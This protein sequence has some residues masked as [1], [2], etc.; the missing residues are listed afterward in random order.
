MTDQLS[1]NSNSSDDSSHFTEAAEEQT[2]APR[3]KRVRKAPGYLQE[4][5]VED[6]FS[7]TPTSKFINTEMNINFK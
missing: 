1:D 4:S 5:V 6:S 3:G 2:V 7:V